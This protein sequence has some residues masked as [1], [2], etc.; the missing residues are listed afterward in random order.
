[1][2]SGTNRGEMPQSDGE[3]P[4]LVKINSSRYWQT[5]TGRTFPVIAGA[6]DPPPAD[7]NTEDEDTDGDTFD[8]D[9][10]LAT[11]R[12]QREREKAAAAELKAVRAEAAALKAKEQERADANKS[13]L[14]KTQARLAERE[15]AHTEAEAKLKRLQVSQA[16]ERAARKH[17]A[18]NPEVVA[19]LIDQ[20]ALEFN[21][22]GEPTNAEDLVKAL[23]KAETYLVGTGNGTTTGVPATPRGSAPADHNER[24]K[25]NQEILRGLPE[26]QPL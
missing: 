2:Y 16:I 7:A 24:V 18:R 12:K 23:L 13:E 10:A 22:S 8:K 1:M 20:D 11:I 17:N 19:K 9:R 25:A 5:S 3:M 6:E 26:R 4:L 14:E 15:K 21:E